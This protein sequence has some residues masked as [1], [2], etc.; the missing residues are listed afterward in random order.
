M[1]QT[2]RQMIHDKEA[3]MHLRCYSVHVS[4]LQVDKSCGIGI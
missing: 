1:S 3:L 4:Q 2:Y